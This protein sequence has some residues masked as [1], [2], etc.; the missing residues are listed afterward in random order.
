MK[1]MKSKCNSNHNEYGNYINLIQQINRDSSSNLN[2][3]DLVIHSNHHHNKRKE[4]HTL[5][6]ARMR[7]PCLE[8]VDVQPYSPF[9]FFY[10]IPNKILSQ[11]FF[12]LLSSFSYTSV[13]HVDC[14]FFVGKC[15]RSLHSIDYIIIHTRHLFGTLNLFQATL[16]FGLIVFLTLVIWCIF[17]FSPCNLCLDSTLEK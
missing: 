1:H 13:F 5:K 12:H 3:R 7:K 14:Y 17:C 2:L 4:K 16:I 9:Q 8:A 6:K 15:G 11:I 10:S